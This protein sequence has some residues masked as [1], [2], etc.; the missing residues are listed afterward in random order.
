MDQEQRCNTSNDLWKL[1][2]GFGA[3]IFA[4]RNGDGNLRD[5]EDYLA[6][7]IGAISVIRETFDNERRQK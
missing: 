7:A 2:S 1:H 5:V 3:V 4:F 6:R